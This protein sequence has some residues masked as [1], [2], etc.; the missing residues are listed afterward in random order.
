MA[1]KIDKK[2]A[3]GYCIYGNGF[4]CET[5]CERYLAYLSSNKRKDGGSMLLAQ[6][7]ENFRSTQ[8]LPKVIYR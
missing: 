6:D 4:G 2:K 3:C 8:G 5:K 7:C 1:K